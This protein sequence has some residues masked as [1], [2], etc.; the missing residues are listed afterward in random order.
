M[1]LM[2]TI[3]HISYACFLWIAPVMNVIAA[4][5]ADVLA[6][7]TLPASAQL[8]IVSSQGQFNGRVMAMAA[9]SSPENPTSVAAFF[10][11]QWRT[12]NDSSTPASTPGFIENTL[13][14]WQLI[15]RM[16]GDFHIVVQLHQAAD[17][18][19]S[20]GRSHGQNRHQSRNK[21]SNGSPKPTSGTQGFVSVVRLGHSSAPANRGP[22]ANLQRLSI[23]QTEDGVDT[24]I[25]SV[26]GSPSSL[27]RTHEL[28]LPKLQQAGWHVLADTLVDQGWVSTLTRDQSRLELAFLD[29]SEFGSVVVAHE[30]KSK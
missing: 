4:S 8:Q 5:E 13:P 25:M 23:N 19:Q 10:K 29:S 22:F 26:Y 14:G 12:G 3:K 20:Q 27:H 28:Y 17:A 16:Q 24:S 7:L 15:S 21:N 11:Q 30:L 9:L 2:I 18:G 1:T 6:N